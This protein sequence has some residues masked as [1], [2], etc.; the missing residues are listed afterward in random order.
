MVGSI[1][2]EPA[3]VG[4]DEDAVVMTTILPVDPVRW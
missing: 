1:M 2:S 4:M 3:T